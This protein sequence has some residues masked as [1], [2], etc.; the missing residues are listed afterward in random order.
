MEQL[1]Q[2]P[3]QTVGPFF[4][5][6]LTAKQY[7]YPYDSLTDEA[8]VGPDAPGPRIY[9]TG[10]L[11]DGQGAPIPDAIVELWQADPQGHHRTTSIDT[12]TNASNR[13]GFVGFGRM[14]TGTMAPGQF[15]FTTLKPGAIDA[16]SAPH[17][18]V[19][20]MMRGSLRTLFTRLYFDDEAEAND[21]DP[22]FQTIPADRRATLL[23]RKRT[24]NDETEYVFDIHMQG[25]DETVFF[26]L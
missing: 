11:Y 18:D 26:D 2:T 7:D 1:R 3:S 14:G 25:P 5:Y 8:L 10:T 6:S 19:I 20:L 23:A 24:V 21:R 12:N 22:L 9:I 16:T 13:R 4:A 15:R 17:I